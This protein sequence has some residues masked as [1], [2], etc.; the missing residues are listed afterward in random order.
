MYWQDIDPFQKSHSKL[1][2]LKKISSFIGNSTK[3][4]KLNQEIQ[5]AKSMLKKLSINEVSYF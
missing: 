2:D 5:R 1:L 3:Q 4:E